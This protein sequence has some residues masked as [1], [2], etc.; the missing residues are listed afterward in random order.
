MEAT[1]GNAVHDG[2][3]WGDR[4]AV[5]RWLNVVAGAWLFFSAFMWLHTDASMTNTWIV[6]LAILSAACA[7]MYAA[8]ARWVNTVLALWLFFSGLVIEHV[9]TPTVVNNTIV[10]AVVFVA[11]LV[12]GGRHDARRRMS[13]A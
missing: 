9:G 12:S 5:A 3:D 7:A 13:P 11:S 2:H 6:G 10:A 1:T 8:W 4:G